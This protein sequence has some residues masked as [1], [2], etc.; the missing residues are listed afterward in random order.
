N[1]HSFA[2]G[3]RDKEAVSEMILKETKKGHRILEY[4]L[5][6]FAAMLEDYLMETSKAAALI[7]VL[8]NHKSATTITKAKI[9]EIPDPRFGLP[10]LR[11]EYL[12]SGQSDWLAWSSAVGSRS[13]KPASRNH[14]LKYFG[15]SSPM[16]HLI[17][18]I[19]LKS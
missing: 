15:N 19:L 14:K 1:V 17:A 6:W 7:S 8:F 16:N 3:I 2:A 9:L 12:V 5:F 11:N 13:L 4:Q 10:E 18:T